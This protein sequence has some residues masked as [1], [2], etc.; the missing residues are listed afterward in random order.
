[1]GDLLAAETD[2]QRRHALRHSEG[3]LWRQ[4]Q[5]W[6]DQ[7]LAA[8]ARIAATLDFS[9]ESDVDDDLL[10]EAVDI[11][12]SIEQ[13]MATLLARPTADRLR[14]GVRVVL[15][16][17]PNSGKSSLLNLL[18]GRDAAIVTEIAGTTRDLLEA[19]VSLNGISFVLIDS[20]GIRASDD[21]IEREGVRRAERAIEQADIVLA[22]GESKAGPERPT[23]RVISKA[24]L[25]GITGGWH[26]DVL[27][28]SASDGRGIE[29]LVAALVE[30]ANELIPSPDVM[31]VNA[32]QRGCILCAQSALA[33][34]PDLSDGVLID[35]HIRVALSNLGRL[36]GKTDIEDVLDALFGRFCIGK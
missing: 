18:V 31:S 14:D 23:I 25:T 26:D 13:E 5:L 6:Q 24:D 28:L 35:E 20:A 36:V 30:R 1:M 11:V 27:H 10:K 22:L 33:V 16:G 34:V 8:S 2:A 19:P 17:P 15:T 29:A 4:A 3:Y 32:R 21:V 9:D 12:A 7:L